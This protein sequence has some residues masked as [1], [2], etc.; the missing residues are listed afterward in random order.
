MN[1]TVF[2]TRKSGVLVPSAYVN[3]YYQT[4]RTTGD[5]NSYRPRYPYAPQDIR[6]TVGDYDRS[7]LVSF[8]RQLF[9]QLGNLSAAILQKNNR[10]V[11][12]SWRAQY[13]GKNDAWGEEAESWLENSF[14]PTCDVRGEPYDFTTNLYLSGIAWDVDGEDLMILTEN[15]DN[16]FPMLQ[17]LP[18][19]RINSS[20]EQVKDGPMK[21]AKV[22][23][24]M[25]Y[26]RTGKIIGVMITVDD[27]AE[28]Q[29]ISIYNC[30]HLYDPRWQSQNRGYPAAATAILDWF[31]IQ[32]IDT[33]L[34]RGVKKAASVGLIHETVE[35]QAD[36]GQQFIQDTPTSDANPGVKL[37]K[38]TGGEDYYFT[39]GRNE[40]LSML[41]FEN[42]SSNVEAYIARLERRGLLAAGWFYELLDPS[43][44]GGASVRMIQD[45]ARAV[46]KHRQK[47]IRK[48]AKRAVTYA[49]AKGMKRGFISKN[50]SDWWMWDFEMP[51]Q[52][53]VDAGNDANSDM[54]ALTLGTMTEEEYH[55]KK[56]DTKKVIDV[57]KDREITNR[58]ARAQKISDETKKPFDWVYQQLW[59]PS[60]NPQILLSEDNAQETK[61][62]EG[63]I[64]Q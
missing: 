39:A 46:V 56:G 45:E 31:D 53:T 64:Q 1:P 9:S 30:Q 25:V 48:R 41:E 50:N 3:N 33:F 16:G 19:N 15:P 63:I 37:E 35:G 18:S 59:N 60:A 49:I 32:D 47:L 61:A 11:G 12:E 21:G 4:P 55:S 29:A 26:D 14:Y 40:K 2:K 22:M 24:G 57:I 6:K 7:E 28:P 51:A 8:S 42:P 27:Q 13:T 44:I 38:I 10:A 5:Y 23:N 58:I 43:K 54:R 52:I 62:Q 36:V 17:F 34:K 20:P